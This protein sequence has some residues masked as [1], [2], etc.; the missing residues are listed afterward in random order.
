L[1]VAGWVDTNWAGTR[2]DRVI[3]ALKANPTPAQA[4]L[5]GGTG[6]NLV[7]DVSPHFTYQPTIS[8]TLTS[9]GPD[10]QQ[11]ISS[12]QDGD[13]IYLQ[14]D[15]YG[16]T[17]IT[18]NLNL[19]GPATIHGRIKVLSS[20][21]IENIHFDISGQNAY[22]EGYLNGFKGN[23]ILNNIEVYGQNNTN[24]AALYFFNQNVISQPMILNSYV[25]DVF[26]DGISTGGYGSSTNVNLQSRLELF[27]IRGEHSG[28]AQNNQVLTAHAGFNVVDVLGNN[29]DAA[30]NVV[31]PDNLTKI[32]MYWTHVLAGSR[33]G[34]VLLSLPTTLFGCTLLDQNRFVQLGTME[35]CYLEGKVSN[36][37]IDSYGTIKKCYIKRI[38]GNIPVRSFSGSVIDSV[39][40]GWSSQILN[41]GATVEHNQYL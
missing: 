14:G 15:F 17:T 38:T 16:D 39:F 18:K 20:A 9:N 31:A 35:E 29:K 21:Y 22:P 26:G 28:P 7:Y 40:E 5:D 13:T 11:I 19:I 12:A 32:D 1:V 10:L 3:A 41:Q 33:Q 24:V 30:L 34:N 37:F 2:S 36:I 4:E 23:V 25:H 27:N 8:R 6:F